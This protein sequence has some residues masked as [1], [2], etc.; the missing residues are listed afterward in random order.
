MFYVYTT[1]SRLHEVGYGGGE[2]IGIW[3]D[4]FFTFGVEDGWAFLLGCVGA[5]L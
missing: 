4:F 3:Y 1:A 2:M 5:I